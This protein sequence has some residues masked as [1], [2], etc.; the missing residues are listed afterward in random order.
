MAQA[1]TF[2]NKAVSRDDGVDALR[3]LACILLVALHVIGEAPEHGLRVAADHPLSI[4]AGLAFHLRMPLFAML[5][6]FV[7]AYRPARPGQGGRFAQG[8]LRRIVLPYLFAA[9]AFALVNTVLGG[10]FAVEP[11]EFWQVYLLPY[12]QFWFLQAVLILFAV[13]AVLDMAFP[14]FPRAVALGALAGAALLFLS[15]IGRDVEW[16]S[17][18]RA[19]YLAPFFFLGL[20][21]NRITPEM[22]KKAGWFMAGVAAFLFAVHAWMEFTDPAQ[23]ILR[24]SVMGIGLGLTLSGALLVNRLGFAPLAAIGRYSFAIYLYH[25]FA[26]MG[27][28]LAY[29]IVFRP[30]PMIGFALGV[31]T[32]IAFPILAH[33]IAMRVGAVLP[34]IPMVT[35]GETP[36]PAREPGP[37]GQP[38]AAQAGAS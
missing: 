4:F 15:P 8:K 32:G 9:T 29:D 12:A 35:L 13:I 25:M 18:D 21:V 10:A 14:K 1:Q 2:Q 24:R 26:I 20:A 36:K 34:L 5:S 11:A 23:T 28:Q 31:A 27:L 19:I 33:V 16:L 3:G 38:V 17:L 30:D 37:T 7:Y 6:G 22:A